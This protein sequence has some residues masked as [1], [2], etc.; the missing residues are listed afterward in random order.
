MNL[1]RLKGSGML[2]AGFESFLS[3]WFAPAS[4]RTPPPPW[5]EEA[6]EILSQL[7]PEVREFH[8]VLYRWPQAGLSVLDPRDP[9]HC[10]HHLEFP[11]WIHQDEENGSYSPLVCEN[12]YCFTVWVN[13]GTGTL[14][15]DAHPTVEGQGNYH[16]SAPVDEYLVTFGL[17][18]LCYRS[19]NQPHPNAIPSVD[20]T[21][22]TR[23]FAGRMYADYRVQFSHHESG[24]FGFS[25]YNDEPSPAGAPFEIIILRHP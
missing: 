10:S 4:P 17:M 24:Q 18:E 25:F 8:E 20:W 9:E 3:A 21:A 19:K 1:D 5:P 7:P 16:M 12:Q 14:F 23:I 11:K 6:L 22:G 15:T 13:L 2:I